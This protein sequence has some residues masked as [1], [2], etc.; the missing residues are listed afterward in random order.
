MATIF[1][2]P[3]CLHTEIKQILIIRFLRIAKYHRFDELWDCK[4]DKMYSTVHLYIFPSIPQCIRFVIILLFMINLIRD[5][6]QDTLCFYETA[7]CVFSATPPKTGL[8]ACF[9]YLVHKMQKI[10]ICS[11]P[12]IHIEWGPVSRAFQLNRKITVRLSWKV[13]DIDLNQ[14]A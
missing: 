4:K 1:C 6:V 3:V 8:D 9:K 14:D 13:P 7:R 10:G 12:I 5:H 2:V 11:Y